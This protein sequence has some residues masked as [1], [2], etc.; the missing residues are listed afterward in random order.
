MT[1]DATEARKG[2]G[3]VKDSAR[4]M[5]QSVAEQGAAAGRAIDSIGSGATQSAQKVDAGT[6]SMIQSIQRQTAATL[7]GLQAGE[8]A[9]V[10]GTAAYYD[11]LAAQRG[12]DPAKI[13]PYTDALRE[14]QA[15]LAGMS[16]SLSGVDPAAQK[17]MQ[18][19]QSQASALKDQ[20]ATFGMSK[21]ELLAY[22][23]AQLGVGASATSL[24]DQIG[25]QESALKSLRDSTATAA[26]SVNAF[27]ETG[28]E[29]SARIKDM[30]AHSR[31]AQAA[32]NATASAS[33]AAASSTAAY[34]RSSEDV[35][36]TVAAQ[37]AAMSATSREMA[38]V[39]QAME[40][41]RAGAAQS[42][43]SFAALIEQENRLQLVMASGKLS[44]EEYDALLA[45]LWK[46]E[47]RLQSQLNSVTSRYDPL[48]AATRK[49]ASD[50]GLLKDAF[51]HGRLSA[52]QYDKAIAGIDVDHAVV[53]LK[54]LAQQEALAE[55]SF[56]SGAT[57]YAQ[58]KSAMADI[59]G[60][61][62]MLNEVADGATS[63]AKAMDSLGL[64]TAGARKELVVL[65]HEVVTGSWSNLGG[66]L[67][68]MAERMDVVET[69]TSPLVLGFTAAAVAATAFAVAAVK[70][71]EES[72][73]LSKALASTANYAG[74]TAGQV[75]D[76]AQ[77]IG[78]SNGA[79]TEAEKAL[80]ALVASGKV[81]GSALESVGAAAVA[82][83]EATGESVD[84]VVA[85]FVSMS[86]DVAKGAEK[87]NEQYHFLTLAQ[88]DEIKALEE[89]GDKAAAMKLAAD[90]LTT[91]L[92][93]QKLPLGA[94]PQLLKE[95]EKS[96][97]DFWRAAMNAGKPETPA[98]AVNA[99]RAAVE[100][101]QQQVNGL[102]SAGV[103]PNADVMSHLASLQ[104]DL[105][106]AGQEAAQHA[107]SAG[108]QSMLAQQQADGISASKHIDDLKK[109][110]RSR[111]QIRDDE[112]TS[113]R[114]YYASARAAA[115]ANPDQLDPANYSEAA[116]NA[117][118]AAAV[119][120]SAKGGSS[121][122]QA[123]GN[124]DA[125]NLRAEIAAQEQ[126]LALMD[127]YSGAQGKISDGDKKVLQIEQQLGLAQTDRIGKV[128]D[129]QLK[130]LLGYAQ[131]LAAVE[132]QIQAKKDQAAA[133]KAYNEQIDKWSASAQSE[134]D[135]LAQ[136][137][138]LYGTEGEARKLMG[139]QLQYEAQARETI[140]KAQRDGHPLSE[141][142][143][144][145]LLV[146]ADALAKVV[147]GYQAQRDAL[148]A[149]T[150][151][152]K[153]NEQFA[154]NSIADERQRNDALVALDAKKWQDLIDNAGDGTEAQKRLI[155]QYNQWLVN[156][157]N[158]PLI[159]QWKHAID[160]F[161]NDF[162]DGFLLMLTNG[163]NSWSSFTSSLKNTFEST[164]VDALY[165]E[166]A[167]PFVVKVVAQI[168]G[169][170]SGQGV[171]SALLGTT[172]GSLTDLS[173]LISSGSSLA[174][175][176]NLGGTSSMVS[177]ASSSILGS[178]GGVSGLSTDVAGN[179]ASASN[180]Y[181]AYGDGSLI[182][183]NSYGFSA[184]GG[185]GF[186][187]G[188]LGNMNDLGGMLGAA[189]TGY[190]VGSMFGG[191][192]SKI[193]GTLGGLAGSYVGGPV[194]A[195]IGSAL[196]G[197]VG[198]L[199]GG[200]ETRNGA[201][202]T[203]DGTAATKVGTGPSGG[204]P[205]SEQVTSQINST[206]QTIQSMATSLGGSIADLGT[207]H[208]GYEVSPKK[209]NSFVTAGFTT[210][211]NEWDP[212]RVDLGGVKDS[213][214][215]LNDLSLQL[216]RSV[217]KSLQD[218]NLDKPYADY[219]KQFDASTL[220]SDQVTQIESVLNE[221]KSLFTA[222]QT[223]GSDFDN[224]K[225]ASTDAQLAVVNL[226][227]G[228]DQFNTNA[229][230]FEQNFVPAAEQTANQA[231]AVKDQLAALGESSVTTNEQFRQ[232]VE[233]ID[234][235]T[236]A[237]QQLYAQMLAL[238][239]AFNT[240][241]QAAAAAQQA[242]QEAADQQQSLWNN[243]YSAIYTSDQQAAVA[244][245]QLK[246]QF[247][248]LGVAMPKTNAEFQALVE[249]MDT[250]SQPM[251]DLQNAL[252]A[253][254]PTFGQV[255]SA[256]EQSMAAMQAAIGQAQKTAIS[257]LSSSA[258]SLYTDKSNA[259]S[260]LDSI[261]SSLTGNDADTS[262]QIS[263]LWSEMTG[264]GVS[265][266]QQ[267]D[268]ATQ[269]NDL[270]T[271]RYQTE[272]QSVS[273]LTDQVKQIRDY[274]QSLKAGDL[275]TET[276]SEK[277]ADAAQLY[278]DT[279][280]KAQG[281]DQTAIGN[282]STT[283]DSYLKLAQTYY[284]SSDTYTQIFA[285]VTSQLSAFGDSLNSQSQSSDQLSQQSLDQLTQL[286]DIVSGQVSSASSQYQGVM[287]QLAQQLS[288]LDAIE[289]A[290]GIQSEVPSI[291]QGLPSEIAAQLASIIGTGT[292]TGGD[293]ITS[294]YQ[295]MLGRTPTANEV[296]YWTDSFANGSKTLSD[297]KYSADQELIGDAYQQILGRAADAGGLQFYT[298]QLYNGKETLDQIK[299]DLKNAKLTGAYAV[300]GLAPAGLALVGEN[301]P[302][303]VDFKSPGRVYTNDQLS[304]ALK[305]I[306]YSKYG[307]SD[308]AALI[309]E[310]KALNSRI[311]QLESALVQATQQNAAVVA[312]ATTQ[313]AQTIVAGSQDATD[314]AVRTQSARPPKR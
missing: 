84:K 2:F 120:K 23:A 144:R 239:P 96:W 52:E 85:Q 231:K 137:L 116:E 168:A 38:E 15:A 188:G 122:A 79:V 28:D 35:R 171:Q 3:D 257:A 59:A 269:L 172:G 243:Y 108:I 251:K 10:K 98:D 234:L 266:T 261:N 95:A 209:G 45:A 149:A 241:T 135:A 262:A 221:L 250:S 50:E 16:G 44:M 249:N 184:S 109:N 8:Q 272:T 185:G 57:S 287:G 47:D 55:R 133:Q 11:L 48:G 94:L 75:D 117:T 175:L 280:A 66:S 46:D 92:E 235:S 49:L 225:S 194:G 281:G 187:L 233:G 199:F 276:P 154:A 278:A 169:L 130:E 306:D 139:T 309:T 260:L 164:V 26:A 18:S 314:L 197:L 290:A 268:L 69:L 279:L 136:D 17:F 86:D 146:R 214:T 252:L 51:D 291:L 299:G 220:S 298:D 60:S 259:S 138:A 82:M 142:E 202:Y 244:Q 14:A 198:S 125:A 140:N 230:Y 62:A 4:D 271:K 304:T 213:T 217:I 105:A 29:A 218:A 129:A 36:A 39:N 296:S 145:D 300:G 152:Q 183:S 295:S 127:Q 191:T 282:L 253:L 147:G 246:A 141:Q 196:G 179:V 58:Y 123:T 161:G 119:A 189:G 302:E 303:I 110:L 289:Q 118:V 156:Q 67:M 54:E 312:A 33:D 294:L 207:Y 30:V 158:K 173:G 254:A 19:L 223:M 102:K 41:L 157:Y 5:V 277:L 78:S 167:K 170:V 43:T 107:D 114:K 192:G 288:T 160:Q 176:L 81:S 177:G 22:Q 89:H 151:L 247:D 162:H 186:N 264:G 283:A 56:K 210:D 204:D 284:A 229:S 201:T 206:F 126:Q 74:V 100:D 7:A 68:V 153:Q 285:S 215:V 64:H 42:A 159:D 143:Q 132:K 163:K 97:S 150:Q 190:M 211:P 83:S 103:T 258:Q 13:S 106:S 195:V 226:S 40:A 236:A 37:N 34:G 242:A 61:R 90:A 200:G 93:N 6:R 88:Y 111:E 232:A 212:G 240:M 24:I 72:D 265:L 63:G 255:A 313:S 1:V 263:S 178:L 248:A 115:Q 27:G 124:R 121:N 273:A 155:E 310:V 293:Q 12:L 305:P 165:T 208:A 270:I 112:I 76:M 182:G 227:G 238:A 256:A 31:E 203:T 53:G 286:R 113:I 311:G 174:S 20:V 292:A 267:I 73:R 87:M 308:N 193:G 301:G 205:A 148:A 99:A 80:T 101:F 25:R 237:G 297:F 181:S 104:Q 245:G 21:T 134:Q 180:L 307:T 216:Q 166:F 91:S 70:G 128:S 224:L 71:Y 222:I 32:M 77:R 65:A 275:S 9:A 131:T 219:L 274:V 228:I